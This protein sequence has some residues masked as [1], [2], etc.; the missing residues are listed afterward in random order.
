MKYAERTTSTA[1]NPGSRD[2]AL[3]IVSSLGRLNKDE[4]LDSSDEQS[5]ADDFDPWAS[6]KKY[7]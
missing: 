6:V 7:I 3:K 1:K 5:E 4:E 2:R